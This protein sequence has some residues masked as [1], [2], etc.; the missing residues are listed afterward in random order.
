MSDCGRECVS[1]HE[2]TLAEMLAEKRRNAQKRTG[3]EV[4][5]P[6]ASPDRV[7][8]FATQPNRIERLSQRLFS[9]VKDV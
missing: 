6:P 9:Y 1:E 7:R 5:P 2:L 3:P 4:L 8:Q